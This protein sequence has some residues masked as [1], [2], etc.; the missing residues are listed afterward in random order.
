[1]KPGTIKFYN[2]ERGFGFITPVEGGDDVYFGSRDLERNKLDPT[3][4]N[5]DGG[6][7]V[8]FSARANDKRDGQRVLQMRLIQEA[9]HG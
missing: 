9:Q 3:D 6:S 4:I 5:W 2:N 8:E 7:R 1:M